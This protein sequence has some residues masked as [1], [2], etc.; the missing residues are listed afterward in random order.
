[1]IRTAPEQSLKTPSE[2]LKL[3]EWAPKY[4]EFAESKFVAKT[5]DEK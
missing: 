4:L 3:I 2:S 1:M 5:F